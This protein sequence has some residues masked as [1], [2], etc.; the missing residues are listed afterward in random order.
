MLNDNAHVSIAGIP[1]M[2]AVDEEPHYQHRFESLFAPTSAIAGEIARQ[3][4]R[5]EKLLWSVTD[6]SGGEGALIYYPQ[7]PTTYDV[8]SLV[9]VTTRGKLT[10]RPRRYRSAVA[11]DGA[12]AG[13]DKR[14]A[15]VSSF[16]HAFI[17]WEDN[18]ISSPNALSWSANQDTSPAGSG[19]D[20]A[21]AISDGTNAAFLYA[22]GGT[23]NEIAVV[24]G[25]QSVI[26]W[27]DA[28]TAAPTP[29]VVGAVLDGIPYTFGG[30]TLTLY[31]KAAVMDSA[32]DWTVTTVY[33]TA[34]TPAGTWGE[35]YWT[36]CTAAETSL[37]FSY[38]TKTQ[39]FVWECRNAVGRPFWT[40]EPGFSIKKLVYK[41]G[42]LFA[43]GNQSSSG[44]K[45]FAGIW[46]I[47]LATRSPIFI[48]APRKHQNTQLRD[49][50]VGCPGP[51][52]TIFAGD[53]A[54]GKIFLYDIERDAISL[55]DD[56]ANGGTGD[57][58]DFTAY[59]N[60]LSSQQASMET[61]TTHSHKLPA[62]FFAG[63]DGWGAETNCAVTSS[64]TVGG[65][66]GLRS[67]RLASS[68]AGTMAAITDTGTQG[69]EV[70]GSTQYTAIAQFR[71][72]VNVRACNVI[73]RW[74]DSTGTVISS[75][76]GATAND[77]VGSW[78][79][80]SVTAT[81]PAT[82]VYAAV[83]AQV[84][85]TG[86]A[87]EYHYVDGVSLHPG[88][89]TTPGDKI[90]FLNLH[91]VRLFGATYSPLE[92]AA[93]SLQVFSYDD[94]VI[95]NRDASQSISA[96]LETAE[97]DFGVPM[98]QKS[99]VGFYVTYEITDAAT[100]SGLIA[101]SR[102][103]VEYSLDGAAYVTAAT[104]TSATTPVGAKGRHFL[105]IST[106]SSTYKFSRL[107]LKLTL[108]NN[109]TAGVAPPILYGV[110]AEAQLLAYAETWDLIVRVE[111]EDSN[112]RPGSRQNEG[113]FLRDA[114]EDLAQNKNVVTFLDGYRY[115][116]PNRYTSHVVMVEDPSDEVRSL[117]E[118]VMRVRLRSVIS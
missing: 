68:G 93:T 64:V 53:A 40:S 9:N 26:A 109:S 43:I 8:G 33:S 7:D 102:I 30:A 63:V 28:A 105:Q 34:I 79:L 81:S 90:A 95:Q 91:G 116:Q 98:E 32:A 15:G 99:L 42:I 117:G 5:P 67:L 31:Q 61:S 57:G 100:T 25:D 83:A 17:G 118:G 21:D 104:I 74:Y 1:Y 62:G 48:A 13:T 78:T 41:S 10:T 112:E 2:L 107:K 44:G 77:A 46:A 54:S 35:D 92:T 101:N 23:V 51:G 69:V 76:S 84:A 39:G 56:L 103:K 14:P 18:I 110:T 50:S 80:A 82:A 29:P 6:W 27:A 108:D 72:G 20:Y 87:A 94:L 4:I 55:F 88:S 89:G 60:L 45:Q 73:I 113:A 85:S 37:F 16:T 70:S 12:N 66:T 96:T 71:T 111:D 75:D 22:T 59:G 97:Y 3:Q 115:K 65:Y 19:L 38:S 11:R 47:P 114:L 24:E 86:G 106:G 52:A 49:F 58:M 36:S